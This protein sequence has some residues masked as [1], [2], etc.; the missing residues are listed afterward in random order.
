M[1]ENAVAG[2][3][4]GPRKP[5]GSVPA[6]LESVSSFSKQVVLPRMTGDDEHYHR[7]AAPGDRTS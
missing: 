3:P 2:R 5:I 6:R 1:T 4:Q 7:C